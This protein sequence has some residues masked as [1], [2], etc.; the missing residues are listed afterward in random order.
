MKSV[1]R[2]VTAFLLVTM[3]GACASV[4]HSGKYAPGC[5]AHA[6]DTIEL[7]DGRFVWDKFTDEV[8][9]T[10]DG[11]REDQFPAHPMKGNYEVKDDKLILKPDS[12]GITSVF[13][14]VRQDGHNYV[15]NV[16]QH[17]EWQT[18]GAMPECALMHSALR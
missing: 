2:C 10:A 5:M 17:S 14:L 12:G 1:F 18:T 13:Y 15:M 4:D 7:Y 9:L 3:A 11:Q 16:K 6:G 8:R